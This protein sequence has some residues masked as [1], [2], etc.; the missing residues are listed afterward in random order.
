MRRLL[1]VAL[2]AAFAG[3]GFAQESKPSFEEATVAGVDPSVRNPIRRQLDTATFVD[4]ADLLQLIVSAYLDADGAGACALKISFGDD[5]APIVGS[6][7]AWMR[8]S[9]FEVAAKLPTRSL[10]VEVIDRLRDFRFTSSPRKNVYPLPVQLM[11]RRL[12]E[13]T[14]DVTVR[15]ERKQVPVLAITARTTESTLRHSNVVAKTGMGTNGLVLATRRPGY[16]PIAPDAPW[17]LVFEGSSIKDLA[18]FFSGYLDRPVIDRTGL[19]GEYDFT[20][21]FKPNPGAPLKYSPMTGSLIPLTPMMAGF[22]A[23]RLAAGLDTLGFNLESTTA[24]FDVLVI[25]HMQRPPSN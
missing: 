13:E 11:L 1:T 23:A 5:C 15:R 6:V 16:L 4:R 12:L 9:K 17:Q 14:F 24:P 20:F 10:P 18:D 25:E 19:E 7:P 22:D 3:H 8:T 21:E 2:V